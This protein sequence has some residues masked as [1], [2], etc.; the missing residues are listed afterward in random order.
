MKVDSYV[1]ES[2]VHFPT[3]LNR[4]RAAG[5]QCVDKAMP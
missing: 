4:L 2:D 1:L 5:R 3:D